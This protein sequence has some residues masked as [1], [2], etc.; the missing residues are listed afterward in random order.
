MTLGSLDEGSRRR[1]SVPSDQSGAVVLG[2]KDSSDAGDKG[3]KAG[4]LIVRAGDTSVG[5][6]HDVQTAVA[7]AKKEGRPSIL[8]GI[9]RDGHNYFVPI[10]IEG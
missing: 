3:L 6:P 9:R 10:K 8:L 1:F 4:D 2:V 5:A 7:A